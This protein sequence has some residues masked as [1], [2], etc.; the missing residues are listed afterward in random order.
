MRKYNKVLN[1]MT[2]T[3]RSIAACD[4]RVDDILKR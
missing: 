2:I 3:L 1:R 4:G